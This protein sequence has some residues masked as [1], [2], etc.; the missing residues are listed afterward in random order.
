MMHAGRRLV[1]IVQTARKFSCIAV[2]GPWRVIMPGAQSV[3]VF[4]LN[5][6]L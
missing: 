4:L 1:L 6:A 5:I 2:T 3:G